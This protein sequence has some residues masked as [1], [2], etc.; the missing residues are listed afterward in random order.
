MYQRAIPKRG[1]MAFSGS[2]ETLA[3]LL[4]HSKQGELSSNM[5]WPSVSIPKANHAT[6]SKTE[7]TKQFW[8]TDHTFHFNNG[9]VLTCEQ[10]W[11]KRKLQ[12]SWFIWRDKSARKTTTAPCWAFTGAYGQSAHWATS[13]HLVPVHTEAAARRGGKTSI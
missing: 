1:D 12:K 9:T 13:A 3:T 6:H 11:Q 5:T 2:H 7:V 8:V 10:R 4:S